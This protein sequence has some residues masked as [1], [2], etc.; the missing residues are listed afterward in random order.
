[1]PFL[2]I[3]VKKEW[4]QLLFKMPTH[5]LQNGYYVWVT[6][7]APMYSIPKSAF[8]SFANGAASV[9][10]TIGDS[11]FVANGGIFDNF[12]TILST[13]ETTALSAMFSVLRGFK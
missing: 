3:V 1:M 13:Q 11:R 4:C 2:L 6:F 10:S 8:F 12:S 7:L 9:K 5:R